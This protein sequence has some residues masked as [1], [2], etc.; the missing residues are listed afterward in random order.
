MFS[1]NIVQQLQTE[2]EENK[3]AIDQ[4]VNNFEKAQNTKTLIAIF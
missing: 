2:L 4:W 1:N 3:F